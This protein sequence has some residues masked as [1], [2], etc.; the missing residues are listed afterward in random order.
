MKYV[1]PLL[2]L[3]AAAAAFF[4]LSQERPLPEVVSERSPAVA[5]S[6]NAEAAETVPPAAVLAAPV[7]QP[8][9]LL[10][11]DAPQEVMTPV[12]DTPV[13]LVV[14][15]WIVD[16]TGEL[17]KIHSQVIFKQ[18]EAV[19]VGAVRDGL[20]AAAGLQPG[21]WTWECEQADYYP[22]RGELSL[23]DVPHFGLRIVLEKSLTVRV[24]FLTPDGA[25]LFD[26]LKGRIKA[27]ATEEAPPKTL[28]AEPRS[29]EYGVGWYDDRS[30]P[31]QGQKVPPGWDGVLE[32]RKPPP[33]WI[34]AVLGPTVVES[35]LL[36]DR[37]EELVLTPTI[38]REK[39]FGT[40]RLR[41]ADAKTG[42][43]ITAGKIRIERPDG[44]M[45]ELRTPDANGDV[46]FE[47][48]VPTFFR[49]SADC[50]G[51]E[52]VRAGVILKPGMTTDLGIVR[53]EGAMSLAGRV[54]D[55]DGNPVKTGIQATNMD[56][57]SEHRDLVS[58]ICSTT[59]EQGRFTVPRLGPGRILL[60]ER[61]MGNRPLNFLVVDMT[62][63]PPPEVLFVSRPGVAVKVIYPQESQP[64]QL[65]IL[66]GDVPV[67]TTGVISHTGGTTV[68]L[69][70]GEYVLRTTAD[71]GRTGDESFVIDT[72]PVTVTGRL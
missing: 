69:V 8:A 70:A 10:A 68:Q 47:E 66:S 32:L 44:N 12:L 30:N 55:L 54:V 58:I 57:L 33:V 43:P 14:A 6:R 24:K 13:G 59:D 71:D 50:D 48:V 38:E 26:Q 25:S 22:A 27:I 65:T 21:T 17:L 64:I 52:L 34:S 15:G 45:N 9:P 49:F 31:F 28:A 20:L 16:S 72:E 1:L 46:M 40:L 7:E 51:Y 42:Q 23:A 4:L 56:V 36:A 39:L 63:G 3:L 62:N 60:R 5:P 37:R 19:R 61:G 18:G 2:V 67:W 41:L 53:L 11:T 35:V 29:D